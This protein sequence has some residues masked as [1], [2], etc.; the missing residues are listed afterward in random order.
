MIHSDVWGP[1]R[2]RNVTGTRWFMLFVDDHTR[3]TWLFLM[4]EKSKVGQI[5]RKFN[6]MVQT[7][8]Q[9]KMQVL[10]IDKAKE[11]FATILGDYLEHRGIVHQS[12]YV[13]SP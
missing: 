13:D 11:Y 9:T 3:I 5:F 10:K 7:Q 1:S 12:S 2:I 6:T 8:F 4:K